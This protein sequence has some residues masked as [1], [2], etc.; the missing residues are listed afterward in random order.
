MSDISEELKYWVC[1]RDPDTGETGSVRGE[2]PMYAWAETEEVCSY[3][4]DEDDG[5]EYFVGDKD[6]N[7]LMP[8]DEEVDELF[9]DLVLVDMIISYAELVMLRRVIGNYREKIK[10]MQNLIDAIDK[11][12]TPS[13]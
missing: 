5:L 4:R 8:D 6:G 3:F 10:N 1:W 2:G 7:E 9:D 13:E 12:R 11:D